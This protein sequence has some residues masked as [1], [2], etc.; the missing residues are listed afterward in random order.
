MAEHVDSSWAAILDRMEADLAGGI[1][2]EQAN[3]WVT[4]SNPGALPEQLVDRARDLVEAQQ[5][6]IA[7]LT[8]EKTTLGRHL[9]AL[10]TVPS[11]QP[12][13][14]SVYLDVVG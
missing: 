14:Q 8:D 3:T 11:A 1:E 7:A 5:R 6:A 4:P 12:T 9:T 13:G 10:R 2:L